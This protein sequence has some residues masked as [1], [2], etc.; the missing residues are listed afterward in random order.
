MKSERVKHVPIYRSMFSDLYRFPRGQLQLS[1]RDNLPQFI[2]REWHGHE[3]ANYDPSV[4]IPQQTFVDPQ[5]SGVNRYKY[6]R[7]PIIPFLQQI[8]PEVLLQPTNVDPLKPPDY[9]HEKPP[10]PATRSVEVQT[11]Y[12]DSEAQTDP[13]TPEYVVR[14]GS[15]TELLTLATLSYGRGLPAGLAEV[16]MIERAR[17]KRAWEANLPPLHDMSQADKRRR[18]MDE[19]ERQE[20]AMREKEIERL[21]EARLQ[22]LQQI[23]KQRETDHSELNTKRM[24]RLWS[25]KRQE[26]DERIKNIRREHIKGIRKLIAKRENIEGKL[27]RRDI[28]KDY[29]DPGSQ[30]YAPVT[31]Y[32]VFMDQGSEKRKVKSRHL[33]TYEGLLELEQSLPDFVTQPR[34]QVPKL[35]YEGKSSVARRSARRQ[36]E[37]KEITD[38]IAAAKHKA[39]EPPKP[40][41]FLEK[42]EKIIPRPPTP[43]VTPP[44]E[45][46]EEVELAV[47]FLQKLI[48][49]RA[50]Q[51]M[52]YEGKEK[53]V[54]LI[55]E[56][57]STHALQLEQQKMK[58][59]EKQVVLS[60]QRQH[61]LDQHKNFVVNEVMENLQGENIGKMLDYLSKELVRLQE[62]RR[63]HAF[64]ML[65]ERERRMREAEES[66]MRQIEERRR[67]E[68]DEMFKQV[69]KVHQDTVD[70]YLETVILESVQKTADE[71]AVQEIK[72]TARKINIIAHEIEDSRTKLESQEIV[73]ELVNMFLFPEVQ[74]RLIR[75]KV[76]DTQRKYLIAAHA[77]IHGETESAMAE[78]PNPER[79]DAFDGMG[80]ESTIPEERSESAALM[81]EDSEID[82]DEKEDIENAENELIKEHEIAADEMRSEDE[83]D[84]NDENI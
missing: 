14:P 80:R 81:H 41:R 27:T 8:P 13:Y 16:E 44:A 6:H 24:D 51:N 62:E 1:G 18:M 60:K 63:I 47:T 69:V 46:E 77:T 26:N 73:S 15:Q 48:R 68:E 23:L 59:N 66:G 40:L 37:L 31:R 82:E 42:I 55:D 70:S 33:E 30:T 61:R 72:E 45:G 54:E 52:M 36:Q 50:I 2:N 32:G 25:V 58:K 39:K 17:A 20:W 21:Q 19:Q 83:F 64:A 38:S 75:E 67:R 65:A 71:Q 43:T 34:V 78:H 22:V 56:L 57:R 35:K 5:V 4:R 79:P 28:G 10:T 7:R 49:G 76:K 29:A 53:R 9:Y 12:R 3:R 84:E 11:M 74:K